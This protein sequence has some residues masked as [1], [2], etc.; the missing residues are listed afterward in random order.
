MIRLQRVGRRHDPS[1]RIIL[2]EKERAAKTGNYIEM[3]GSYDART[4]K[5]TVDG[6]RVKYWISKGAQL[7]DTVHNLLVTEKLLDAK[8]INVLP[9]NKNRKPEV[10][11][12]P[13][14]ESPAP[15]VAAPAE[16]PVETP[17]EV[18]AEAIETPA[19]VPAEEAPVEVVVETPAEETPAETEPV[20]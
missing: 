9:K 12:E 11:A 2:T 13:V 7:S 19:E 6:D 10:V 17:V 3:L 5:R 8:K 20:A 1:F 14:K 18:V 4:D 16:A 15:V